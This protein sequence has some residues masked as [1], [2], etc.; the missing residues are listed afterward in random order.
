MLLC[1]RRWGGRRNYGELT[2]HNPAKTHLMLVPEA[3]LDAYRSDLARDKTRED[4]GGA[5]T[6]WLLTTHCLSR[7]ARASAQDVPLLGEQCA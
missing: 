7:I 2:A 4:F 6:V 5:D 3:P 1:K